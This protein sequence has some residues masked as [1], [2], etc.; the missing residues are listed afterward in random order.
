MEA[1][2]PEPKNICKKGGKH[3]SQGILQLFFISK[4]G[5]FAF[6]VENNIFSS[7]YLS[8]AKDKPSVYRICHF[9]YIVWAIIRNQLFNNAGIDMRNISGTTTESTATMRRMVMEIFS[10]LQKGGCRRSSLLSSL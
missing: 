5:A 1:S 6:Y 10:R 7:H 9:P 2:S 8:F 3:F 4:G